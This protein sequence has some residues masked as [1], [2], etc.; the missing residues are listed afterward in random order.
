ME[1][2]DLI[3]ELKKLPQDVPIRTLQD[4]VPD[5]MPNEWVCKVEL[6]ETCVADSNNTNKIYREAVLITSQ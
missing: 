5:D 6:H 3:K 1:I 2:K 4:N